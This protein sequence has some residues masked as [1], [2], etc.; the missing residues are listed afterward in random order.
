MATWQ[1]TTLTTEFAALVDDVEEHVTATGTKK[2]RKAQ[3]G[4]GWYVVVVA[5]LDPSD[6]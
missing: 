2:P 3:E 1:A 4:A 6:L 5:F